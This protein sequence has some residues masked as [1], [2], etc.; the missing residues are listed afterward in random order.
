MLLSAASKTKAA[1]KKHDNGHPSGVWVDKSPTGLKLT[2]VKCATTDHNDGRD[3]EVEV[4]N[5]LE[6]P[7]GGNA[8]IDEHSFPR[9]Y[10]NNSRAAITVPFL[11]KL[12][13]KVEN[14]DPHGRIYPTEFCQPLGEFK[15]MLL[16]CVVL[17]YCD[18][19]DK[20]K[21]YNEFRGRLGDDEET[22]TLRFIS[23]ISRGYYVKLNTNSKPMKEKIQCAVLYAFRP[24]R[25]DCGELELTV[26]VMKDG[27]MIEVTPLKLA[28]A[29]QIVAIGGLTNS[30]CDAVEAWLKTNMGACFGGIRTTGKTTAG[31]ADFGRALGESLDILDKKQLRERYI[32][33][34]RAHFGKVM[35]DKRGILGV[36]VAWQRQVVGHRAPHGLRPRRRATPPVLHVR[37]C[38]SALACPVG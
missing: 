4:W 27:K 17:V 20:T 5:Q 35:D 2:K 33:N 8:V 29:T 37:V 7:G 36:K 30:L 10:E 18:E 6:F 14:V 31:A 9:F 13:S 1:T 21:P 28:K 38:G 15:G 19:A 26:R 34:M 16:S 22:N 24:W 3:W 23:D 25:S 32:L 11:G 12:N